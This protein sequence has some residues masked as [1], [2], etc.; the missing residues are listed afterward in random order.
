MKTTTRSPNLVS[1]RNP[2]WSSTKNKRSLLLHLI[3]RIVQ[4]PWQ[5]SK[6]FWELDSNEVHVLHHVHNG[7]RM[8]HS[9]RG[10]VAALGLTVVPRQKRDGGEDRE[11]PKRRDGVHDTAIPRVVAKTRTLLSSGPGVLH[12]LPSHSA[13]HHRVLRIRLHYISQPGTKCFFQDSTTRKM[14]N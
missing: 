3:F 1:Q 12:H 13:I 2:V 8:V 7:R 5:S 4:N 9:G 11:R 6:S 14:I 10:S